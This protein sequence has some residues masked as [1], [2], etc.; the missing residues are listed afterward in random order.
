MNF[1]AFRAARDLVVIGH[2]LRFADLANARFPLWA[3]IG[4]VFLVFFAHRSF[5]FSLCVDGCPC[6][7]SAA[8]LVDVIELKAIPAHRTGWKWL[9]GLFI[10]FYTLAA[11]FLILVAPK[12]CILAQSAHD[13]ALLEFFEMLGGVFIFQQMVAR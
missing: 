1:C 7:R 4:G 8:R 5:A 3:L 12:K 6:T 2:V 11:H 9:S 10:C 13:C